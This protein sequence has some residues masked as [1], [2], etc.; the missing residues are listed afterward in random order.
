MTIQGAR[1]YYRTGEEIIAMLDEEKIAAVM[2]IFDF[3]ND[4]V[5]HASFYTMTCALAN[6]IARSAAYDLDTVESNLKSCIANLEV[7]T[8]GFCDKSNT[9]IQ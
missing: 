2:A 5:S 3:S 6:V 9:G 8:K 1:K 4:E 7:W